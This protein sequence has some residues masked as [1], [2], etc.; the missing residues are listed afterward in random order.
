MRMPAEARTLNGDEAGLFEAHHKQLVRIV[1]GSVNASRQTIEDACAFAWAQL[2]RYQ[3]DRRH[4]RAWLVRVATREAWRLTAEEWRMGADEDAMERLAVCS[5]DTEGRLGWVH[6]TSVLASLGAKESQLLLLAAA[7]YS[8]V[9]I[10]EI[11]GHSRRA[12]ERRLMRARRHL[13]EADR[14]DREGPTTGRADGRT[15]PV[16]VAGA[17]LAGQ[18]A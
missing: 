1:A 12:V 5:T 9:E 11:T 16:R 14:D 13:R 2:L 6:G 15:L 18:A 8:Y 3:P 4:V 10:S 17:S 7:G